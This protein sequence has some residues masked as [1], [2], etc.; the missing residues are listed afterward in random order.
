MRQKVIIFLIFGLLLVTT[1]GLFWFWQNQA[2]VRAL[3]KTLPQGVSVAKSLWG[4]EYKVVNKIDGYSFKIPK[5]WEGIEEI[6]YVPEQEI[7]GLKSTGTGIKGSKGTNTI[8]S[9]D[10]FY[11]EQEANLLEK[12]RELWESSGLVGDLIKINVGGFEIVKGSEEVHLGGT[13]IYFLKQNKKM[14]A[15]N[16][17]SEEFIKEVILNGQW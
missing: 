8:F 13:Y 9:L 5:A 14:Y 1:G 6:E 3:N 4:G 15:F 16:N 10:I 7:M 2:D 17:G 12:A 11:L